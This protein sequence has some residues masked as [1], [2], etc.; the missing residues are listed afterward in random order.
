MPK[1][2]AKFT[3]PELKSYVRTHKINKPE[4]RLTMN[5]SQLVA[6]LKKHGHWDHKADAREKLKGGGDKPI[7]RKKK[8]KPK[9]KIPSQFKNQT[10]SVKLLNKIL[11]GFYK[12]KI[13]KRAES[14]IIAL[15]DRSKSYDDK[16]PYVI[17]VS[18]VSQ[19]GIME[20]QVLNEKQN[21]YDDKS[22][23]LGD[24]A[25]PE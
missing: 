14:R 8:T 24:K 9:L 11:T 4:I 13:N 19:D 25:K 6:G 5:K 22:L 10:Q 21:K 2:N 7:M 18:G 3:L 23:F 12:D 15:I 1:P 16:M 17:N 20:Y